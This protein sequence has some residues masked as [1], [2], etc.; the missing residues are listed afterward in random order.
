MCQIQT[1]HNIDT[2]IL[3]LSLLHHSHVHLT[4]GFAG[5]CQLSG[6]GSLQSARGERERE[7]KWL[8]AEIRGQRNS[9]PSSLWPV[10]CSAQAGPHGTAAWEIEHYESNVESFSDERATAATALWAVK[11]AS[12]RRSNYGPLTGA[13]M[14]CATVHCPMACLH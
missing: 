6:P 2:N 10:L 8:N 5:G 12:R 4:Q 3:A 14:A 9:L 1:R 7:R 13:L 11:L